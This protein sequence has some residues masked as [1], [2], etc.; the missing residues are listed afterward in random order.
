MGR[1]GYS[2]ASFP[3]L[4]VTGIMD[5]RSFRNALGS[6][7]T[8]VT[9]VSGLDGAGKPVGSTVNSFN[10]VSLTPPLILFSW[11]GRPAPARSISASASR[12]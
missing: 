4:S 3:P 8:G 9:I 1:L 6:F 12:L 2:P 11:R 7:A 10:S 5:T